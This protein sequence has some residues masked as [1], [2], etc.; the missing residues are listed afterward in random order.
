MNTST[1]WPPIAVSVL[2]L[3][4]L[5]LRY[6][7][8]SSA[9]MVVA[10]LYVN[11]QTVNAHKHLRRDN[12]VAAKAV[13]QTP[14]DEADE[15]NHKD[16]DDNMTKNTDYEHASSPISKPKSGVD[17]QVR[18]T[19]ILKSRA[20]TFKVHHHPSVHVLNR[21]LDHAYD[22]IMRNGTKKDIYMLPEGSDNV[23]C[24]TL[25]RI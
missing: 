21:R 16:E 1:T 8:A 10:F 6:P 20:D 9:I 13:S 24:S 7:R 11:I 14:D 18:E 3:L 19:E 4:L 25:P 5:S 22:D 23:N 12:S 17:L 2:L 15:K